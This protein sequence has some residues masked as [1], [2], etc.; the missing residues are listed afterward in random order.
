[1]YPLFK[2]GTTYPTKRSHYFTTAVDDQTTVLI[3]VYEGVRPYTNVSTF[4]GEFELKGIPPAKKGVPEIKVTAELD[5]Y[6]L[7]TVSFELYYLS[8]FR[9]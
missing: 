7:L 8:S 5:Y 6:T 9:S 2:R 1:M 3:Q 4:L